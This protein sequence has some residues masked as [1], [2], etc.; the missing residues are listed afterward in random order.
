MAS[1]RQSEIPAST[2][3]RMVENAR[4]SYQL[5]GLSVTLRCI[6]M[7]SVECARYALA[8]TMLFTGNHSGFMLFL[9]QPKDFA[10]TT[11]LM[12]SYTLLLPPPRSY[13]LLVQCILKLFSMYMYTS[14]CTCTCT[15]N[16][17]MYLPFSTQWRPVSLRSTMRPCE[18][19]SAHPPKR[20][21]MTFALTPRTKERCT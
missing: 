1:A 16:K 13:A 2:I 17:I 19:S 11:G 15:C 9:V 12:G 4:F 5:C 8:L 20:R 14:T 6:I 7:S 21:N 10:R 18:T 3:F